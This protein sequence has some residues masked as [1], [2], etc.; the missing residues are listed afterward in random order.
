MSV[1]NNMAGYLMS[2]KPGE[3]DPI[4][5]AD[6]LVECVDRTDGYVELAFDM[7][8]PARRVYLKFRMA[9]LRAIA[10]R[11]EGAE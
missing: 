9:D 2:F 8:S 6:V 3:D 10:T 1:E 7:K 5:D 11:Q 4:M